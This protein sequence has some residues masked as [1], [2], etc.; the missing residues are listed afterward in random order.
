MRDMSLRFYLNPISDLP[1]IYDHG[2]SEAEVEWVLQ[3]PYEDGP[4]KNDSRQAI[5]QTQDGRFLRIIYVPDPI[6]AG[7]FVVTA[8]E[9]S[10]KPLKAYRRRGKKRR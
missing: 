7:V 1:H 5:G 4:S 2:I 10:G 6:G 8:C 9:L 3:R